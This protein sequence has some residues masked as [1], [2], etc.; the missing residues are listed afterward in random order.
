MKWQKQFSKLC[1]RSN[2]YLAL[3]TR[4]KNFYSYIDITIFL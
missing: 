2:N 1:D 3:T 4:I